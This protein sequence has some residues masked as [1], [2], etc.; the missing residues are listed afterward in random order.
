MLLKVGRLCAAGLKSKRLWAIDFSLLFN[1]FYENTNDIIP[2]TIKTKIIAP[3]NIFE[4]SLKFLLSL[5][6]DKN[7]ARKTIKM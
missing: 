1:K 5:L 7:H 6:A 3:K 2:A 4:F